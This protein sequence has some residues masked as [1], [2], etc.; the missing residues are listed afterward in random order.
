MAIWICPT[1][2]LALMFIGVGNMMIIF[3]CV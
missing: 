2:S 1:L 3:T